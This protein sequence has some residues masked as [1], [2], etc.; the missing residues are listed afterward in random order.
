MKQIIIASENPV[1]RAATLQ[2]FETVFNEKFHIKSVNVPSGVADQPMS[3]K[4]TAA[5]SFNRAMNAKA[6]FPY[7]DFW[8]GIEGGVEFEEDGMG[9]FGWVT[10]VSEHCIGKARSATFFLPKVIADRVRGGEELGPVNDSVF[11]KKNTKHDSGAVGLL[12]GDVIKRE[13]LY[14]Q[15][16]VLALI[17]FF[18]SDMKF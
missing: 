14:R 4:E 15:A 5:G 13:G 16:V 1:K 2:A 3:G 6:Q 18:N 11:K 8:V 7:A 10:I 9:A 17:P 12:T